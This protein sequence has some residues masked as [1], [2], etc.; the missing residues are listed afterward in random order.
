MRVI[1]GVLQPVP[2]DGRMRVLVDG[3]DHPEGVAYD[4]AADALWAGGEDG[5]LYRLDTDGATVETMG[6]PG[7]GMTLGIAVDGSG[8]PVVCFGPDGTVYLTDSGTW[9]RNDGRVLQLDAS[10]RA[11]ALCRGLERFPNGLAVSGDG[12]TLWCVESFA[13]TLNR[14]ELH[15]D[16]RPEVI[17]RL[18]GTVP[19]G[20][21]LASDD[22]LLISLYRPERPVG[23]RGANKR[24][25]GSAGD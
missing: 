22:G 25:A 10:G 14:I 17:L 16:G 6:E 4:P 12:R 11:E 2:L 18:D 7:A 21:A 5:Q 3:L 24:P 20:L 8:R 9:G 19:D 1:D 13:P 15:G 23:R